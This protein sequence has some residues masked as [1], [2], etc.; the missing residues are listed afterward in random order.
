MRTIYRPALARVAG[1]LTFA[2]LSFA[3]LAAASDDAAYRARGEKSWADVRVLAD[4]AMEGRRAGTPGHRRAA[5]Y[6][7][8]EFEKAGLKPGGDDGWFQDVNLISRTIREEN[9]SV[10]LVRAS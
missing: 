1:T 4:D 2:A 9:S 3:T 7:A 5:E 8:K 10:T 6:V